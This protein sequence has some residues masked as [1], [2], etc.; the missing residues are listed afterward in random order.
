M[1]ARSCCKED[2]SS[3]LEPWE[4]EE[5][6]SE[7]QLYERGKYKALL[8]HYCHEGL[9]THVRPDG[10]IEAWICSASTIGETEEEAIAKLAVIVK[11]R[12][13]RGWLGC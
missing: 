10:Q 5:Q 13:L 9:Q 12:I 7:L 2:Q 3:K 11:N 1:D 6:A 4:L 8:L